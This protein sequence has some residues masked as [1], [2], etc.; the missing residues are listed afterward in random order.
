M[1]PGILS[2]K[3]PCRICGELLNKKVMRKHVGIHIIKDDMGMVCRFCGMEGC[4][5]EL[6]KG[7]G[8]EKTTIFVPGSNCQYVNKFS[9]K[10]AEKSTLSM[11]HMSM[12]KPTG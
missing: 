7:S 3:I 10:S 1:E 12:H 9:I 5:I 11:Q 4:T 8:K 2:D 6:A